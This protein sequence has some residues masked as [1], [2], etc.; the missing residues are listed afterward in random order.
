M[1][2]ILPGNVGSATAATGYNIANSCRFNDGDSARFTRAF[3]AGDRAL[4]TFSC[5]LK[6]STLGSTQSIFACYNTS[7]YIDRM[8]F[9]SDDQLKFNSL[10]N[11]NINGNII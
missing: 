4:W 3:S 10:H 8:Q 2:L 1:P 11:N 6:R 9:T 7:A 5:W